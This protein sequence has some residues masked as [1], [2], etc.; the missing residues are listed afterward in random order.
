[1]GAMAEQE[2]NP[3]R[4]GFLETLRLGWKPPRERSKT[5]ERTTASI[6]AKPTNGPPA[7]PATPPLPAKP[8]T[9]PGEKEAAATPPAPNLQERMEGLQ[10]WMAEIERKQGRITYFGAAAALLAVVA[11]GAALYFAVTTPNSASKDDF[12]DLEAQVQTLQ[13]E[14]ARATADQ[15][16]LKSLNATIESL[17]TRLAASEQKA[18]QNAAEIA[19][20]KQAQAQAAQQA[21]ATT[22]PAPTPAPTTP[23]AGNTKQP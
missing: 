17:S 10:G 22:T 15:T 13:E 5:A 12:D 20:V 8:T 11:A 14:V 1:M 4:R 7:T 6:G 3:G 21:A 19:A 9:G 23:P 18:N 16:R 2:S